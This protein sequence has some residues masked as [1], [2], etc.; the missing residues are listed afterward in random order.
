MPDERG[1]ERRVGSAKPV[2][3]PRA[4][5]ASF[6]AGVGAAVAD[7]GEALARSREIDRR[8][9]ADSEAA[10]AAVKLAAVRQRLDAARDEA[11]AAP[12]VGAADHVKTME[13]TF[14]TTVAGLADTITDQ[15][16]R[17]SVTT[18]IADLRSNF[19]SGEHS[20]QTVYVA[21]K[22][23]TDIGTLIDRGSAR[24]FTSTDPQAYGQESQAFDEA[25]DA[26]PGFGADLREAVRR[27]G[28]AKL[29][30]AQAGRMERD[31]PAGLIA[32]VD[33]GAFN[34][35]LNADQL[36]RLRTGGAAQL[37][38][39]EA[40][41]R[42]QAAAQVTA[43]RE[44]LAT[45]RAELDTGAGK[46]QDWVTLADQYEAIGDTSAAVTARASG[47]AMM[48]G[49]A[50]R[51]DSVGELD[52]QIAT[53]TAKQGRGGLSPAEAATL[54]G[55]TSLRDQK[56][57]RLGQP[58]GALLEMEFATG[59]P[60]A[61]L[62]P[63]DP[64]SVRLRG[65][66][67]A[68]AAQLA[69]R[70][71]AIEPFKPTELPAIKDLMENGAGGRIQV[72][73]TLAAFGDARV[74]D[75]A[76]RQVSGSGDGAFRIASRML[77]YPAGQAVAT[78]I[79]RGDELRGKQPWPEKAQ[80]LARAD[81]LKYYGGAMRGGDL[82]PGYINDLFDGAMAFYASRS[83]GGAYDAGRFAEATEAVLGRN[84]GRGGVA[85]VPGQGIVIAPPTMAPDAMMTR[86]ARAKNED[87]QAAA[88]GRAPIYSD[89]TRLTRGALRTMLPTLLA[90][91]RYGFRGANGALLHDDR[92]G[93]YAV[94]L[95][96]LP[97]R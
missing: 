29:A 60:I 73:Q 33:G 93:I 34:D 16:V 48:A 8:N 58:G 49:L 42:A 91:G 37:R 64:A 1:Y 24:I 71:N 76:A 75:G 65:Q 27:E 43:T 52:T 70:P 13:A 45:R 88:G 20:W 57:Q 83:N 25:L 84:G 53:L 31:N 82:P 22:S 19:I 11:R 40:Q 56:A 51:G 12:G 66:Q 62:D 46:P 95:E 59:Q 39:I 87:Y 2:A 41:Q 67:A 78:A 86:F 79:V 94:D 90:D 77:T 97:A 96:R 6:G 63:R 21:K 14:D 47:E 15:R 80:R 32:A 18:Q 35:V 81:F 17:R 7:V 4:S 50:H 28:H 92:G 85:R 54:K 30:I 26:A 89:G 69:G 5:A 23:A 72:L 10:D 9:T 44:Q 36:D 55:V 74:I 3:L 61:P 68:Q 38:M